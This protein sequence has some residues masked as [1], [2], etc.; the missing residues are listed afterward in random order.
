MPFFSLM[1]EYPLEV[2]TPADLRQEPQRPVYYSCFGESVFEVPARDALGSATLS[3]DESPAR[4]QQGP[5]VRF[6]QG[7]RVSPSP[8]NPLD[9]PSDQDSPVSS[10]GMPKYPLD[11]PPF[12]PRKRIRCGTPYP[13]RAT[14]PDGDV[15]DLTSGSSPLTSPPSS[16]GDMDIADSPAWKTFYA[17]SPVD[18][19]SPVVGEAHLAAL[20][21]CKNVFEAGQY[22]DRIE[23]WQLAHVYYTGWWPTDPGLMA[24][25]N[26]GDLRVP[27]LAFVEVFVL[28]EDDDAA[29]GASKRPSSY[30]TSSLPM[31]EQRKLSQKSQRHTQPRHPPFYPAKQYS[32]IPSPDE[33]A[34][35]LQDLIVKDKE[36]EAKGYPP[37]DPSDSATRGVYGYRGYYDAPDEDWAETM[38][39]FNERYGSTK[40]K[41]AGGWA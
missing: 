29:A 4:L 31:E 7:S 18:P 39:D 32:T 2:S 27:T 17:Q 24:P 34:K 8:E 12:P 40:F 14:I 33:V 15:V 26:R 22:R 37:S 38:K 19:C 1:G 10:A 23:D 21:S 41:F 30:F 5:K 36:R 25:H 3:E 13:G 9:T 6:V 20:P 11:N 16:L 35:K 28:G